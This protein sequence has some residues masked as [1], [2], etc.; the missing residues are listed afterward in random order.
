MTVFG[1]ILRRAIEAVPGARGAAFADGEGETVDTFSAQIG[2]TG[3]RLI[4]AHWGV[5]YA[6]ARAAWRPEHG[7]IDQLLLEFDTQRV[8]IRRVTGEY[9]VVLALAPEG[10]LAR[11]VRAL[12]R[13]EGEL[14][15]QM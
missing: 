8:L 6:L 7:E 15:E 5:I 1:E 14:R 3:L 4:G 12:D 2:D 9:F 11:A 10:N 13:V